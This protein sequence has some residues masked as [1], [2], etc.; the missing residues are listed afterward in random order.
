MA[1]GRTTMSA[2]TPA[3]AAREPDEGV[4]GGSGIGVRFETDA[5]RVADAAPVAGEGRLVGEEGQLSRLSHRGFRGIG[6]GL[7]R[8]V[9]NSA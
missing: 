1:L 2:A 3:L 7:P 9:S 6:L 4:D 8:T 5:P